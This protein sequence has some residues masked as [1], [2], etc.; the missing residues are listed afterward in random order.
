MTRS[1]AG[2]G[3]DDIRIRILLETVA[4]LQGLR[5]TTQELERLGSQTVQ[6]RNQLGQFTS[7]F[8]NRISEEL[9]KTG[10]DLNA[11]LQETLNP[12]FISSINGINSAFVRT[13]QGIQ[14]Y[15]DAARA[16]N[17]MT[18]QNA[19]GL[20]NLSQA[21]IATGVAGGITEQTFEVFL[22]RLSQVQPTGVAAQRAVSGL[23]QQLRSLQSQFIRVGIEE[24]LQKPLTGAQQ[25]GQ[26]LLLSFSLMQAASGNLSAA[27]FGLGFAVLFTGTAFLNTTT[28][29]VALAAALAA[30]ALD[31]FQKDV[32]DSETALEKANRRI[33]DYSDAINEARGD[34]ELFAEGLADLARRGEDVA[35]GFRQMQEEASK[36]TLKER[37]QETFELMARSGAPFA[38]AFSVFIGEYRSTAEQTEQISKDI[39][40]TIKG[41][42]DAIEEEMDGIAEEFARSEELEL[43]LAP[44]EAERERLR[45]ELDAAQDAVREHY[46]E[47]NNIIRDA[48]EEQID[49]RRQE[50][51]DEI[52]SINDAS[53]A[54]IDAIRSSLDQELDAIR[55]SLDNRIDAIRDSAEKEIE[56]QREKISALEDQERQLEAVLTD[57]Q[58]RREEIRVEVISTE[59]QLAALEREAALTGIGVTE[60]QIKLKAKIEGLEAEQQAVDDGIT[61]H[62]KAISVVELQVNALEALIKKI[63]DSRDSAI[64]AAQKEAKAREDTARKSANIEIEE[65]R[66]V[67]RESIQSA[68]RRADADTESYRRAAD[69]RIKE[70]NRAMNAVLSSLD[71]E[72]DARQKNLQQQEESIRKTDRLANA[73]RENV[74][75]LIEQM[76]R[77]MILQGTL[78]LPLGAQNPFMFPQGFLNNQAIIDFINQNFPGNAQELLESLGIYQAGTRAV[79]GPPGKPQLA[80]V[81]GG[82]EIRNRGMS[83]SG[84]GDMYMTVNVRSQ[85]DI[86]KIESVLNKRYGRRINTTVR[87]GRVDSTRS[88]RMR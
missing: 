78:P 44:I 5:Q 49:L 58:R 23:E 88:R 4:Q 41:L 42:R 61:A 32:L 81:H 36:L 45:S 22:Q 43:R 48:L 76:T 52:D 63:E 50:L 77:L 28:L 30:V 35:A 84:Y 79:P 39:E 80:V 53:T 86:D 40:Q 56:A 64:E 67:T 72:F 71:A 65:I 37:L 54:R 69:S 57:L 7:G 68:Q 59:A 26:G 15:V 62:K 34:N 85:A 12:R 16:S 70:N 66:R 38:G 14:Q 3:G 74:L 87:R 33:K 25:A 46:D 24:N 13:G 75:P 21:L 8:A 9:Q 73:L 6:M 19:Q 17:I 29:T 2:G 60:E 55:E 18:A 82:E 10:Q 1:A 27:M 51:Q 83:D 31:R 47:L 20:T 11:V